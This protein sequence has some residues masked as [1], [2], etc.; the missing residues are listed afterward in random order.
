[1]PELLEVEVVRQLL[2]KKIKQKNV[3][4]VIYTPVKSYIFLDLILL[5]KHIN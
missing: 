4:I 5:K 2:D 1:M 3:K